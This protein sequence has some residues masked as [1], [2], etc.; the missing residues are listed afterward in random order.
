M[1][2]AKDWGDVVVAEVD[3]DAR[4]QWSGI[5]DFKAEMARRRPLQP[6][7]IDQVKPATQ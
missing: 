2:L 1:A 3:L 4:T 5:G 6:A 7:E